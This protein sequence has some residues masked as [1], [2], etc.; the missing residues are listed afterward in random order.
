MTDRLREMARAAI[1][2]Y[3]SALAGGS[4]PE[5]PQWAYDVLKL[6]KEMDILRADIARLRER[7]HG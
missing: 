1:N 5:F 7:E 3:N 6:L 2:E 4:E